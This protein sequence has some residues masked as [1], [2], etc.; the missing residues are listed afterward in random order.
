[1]RGGDEHKDNQSRP[2]TGAI[3]NVAGAEDTVELYRGTPRYAAY[4]GG[5]GLQPTFKVVQ[6]VPPVGRPWM[7]PRPGLEEG[8]RGPTV[9]VTD[10][11]LSPNTTSTS[12]RLPLKGARFIKDGPAEGTARQYRRTVW[13]GG[14]G[15]RRRRT[16]LCNQVSGVGEGEQGSRPPAHVTCLHL[17]QGRASSRAGQGAGVDN[18][19]PHLV[20][21]RSMIEPRPP[22]SV[23]S[24]AWPFT[25]WLTL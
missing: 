12:G 22:R 5:S 8:R 1:M 19:Q 20:I 25:S 16:A 3:K 23:W 11:L 18:G 9:P 21:D 10:L 7:A 24:T 13:E 17:S 4:H 14:G 6:D 2:E 15:M